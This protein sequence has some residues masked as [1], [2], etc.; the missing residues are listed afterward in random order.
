MF[1]PQNCVDLRGD[2]SF[3]EDS[4]SWLS[5]PPNSSPPH[6]QLTSSQIAA[7]CAAAASTSNG[8]GNGNLHRVLFNDLVEIVPLVQSLIDRKA[9]S[10]FTRR[11]SIVYTKTPS[12]ESLSKKVI[13]R[14][15]RNTA[16]SIPAK[17]KGDRGDKDESKSVGNT[18]DVSDFTVFTS[19]AFAADSNTDEL[20]TLREQVE[21]L[22]KKL[23]EKDELAKSLEI[24]ESQNDAIQAELNE[25]KQQVSEKESLI[26]SHQVQL[27]DAKIKLA[28]KQAALE[29]IQWEAMT[30]NN[31]AEKLQ[32]ELDSIQG[33]ISSL[34]LL[35]E[36][37]TKCDMSALSEDYD[38]KPTYLDYDPD[39]DDL[40]DT[41]IREMEEARINYIAA[42]AAAKEKRDEESIIA[43]ALARQHLQFL[44]CKPSAANPFKKLTNAMA[45]DSSSSIVHVR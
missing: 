29:R 36:G 18:Q 1:D 28:D 7:H 6:S 42:V 21:D 20:I 23:S 30:S 26:R 8:G 15:N 2:P 25:L 5:G 27:S 43:A 33:N 32:G 9:S 40:D 17:K 44:L 14:R 19:R 24:S 4:K 31:K 41:D 22:Q 10:S 12:R 34:M 35:F 11:G 3:V 39:I 37:L 13:D 16:Q 38:S 45:S